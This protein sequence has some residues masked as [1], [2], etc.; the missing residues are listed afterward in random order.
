MQKF[1]VTGMSCAACS[2]RV[3]KAVNAVANVA[4]CNVNLLTGDMTVEGGADTQAIIDAVIKAGYGIEQT[5][6]KKDNRKSETHT[7]RFDKNVLWRLIS[8]VI[9]TVVLMY[10][11]MFHTMWNAPLPN[12][13]S[14]NFLAQALI[15]LILTTAVMVI[16]QRFFI[17]GFKG[18]I[19]RAPNMDTLVALGSAAA[20]VYSLANVFL[21]TTVSGAESKHLLHGLYFESAAMILTLITVGKLLEGYA[22]GKTTNAIKSLLELAPKT[23]TVIKDGKEIV[24]PADDVLKD[25]IFVVLPGESLAVDGLVIEGNS[26]V[27]E[28]SLTGE[29]IPVDKFTGSRVSSGTINKTGKLICRAT[30]VGEDST[31]AQI[32]KMVGDAAATKA[33]IARIADRVSAVFVPIVIVISIVTLTVWLLFGETVGFALS[34]AISVLVISCP[35]ALGLATPVAIMVGSGVGARGGILFKNAAALELCGKCNIAVLDKTGTVTT[36]KPTVADVITVNNTE[37]SRLLQIAYTLESGSAHPLASAVN[38]YA[39]DKN[40]SALNISNFSETAGFGVSGI[41]DEKLCF[42][43]S[44]SAAQEKGIDIQGIVKTTDKFGDEGKTPLLFVEDGVL[45]G[46]IAVADTVKNDARDAIYRFKRLGIRVVMLTGDNQKTADTVANTVGIDEVRA[47]VKPDGKAVVVNELK[48]QGRVIMVGDGINDAPALTS[49]DIGMAVGG[50]MD[51]AV[52]SADVVLM[53]SNLTDAVNAV[54]LSRKTLG[55][56]KQ[57]LFWAFIYN[58][59]GIPLAA[60][61]LIPILGL[62]LN[63]MFAAA[64]MSLSSF[65]V[66]TNALRLNFFKFNRR[67]G[68]KTIMKKT[69]KIEGLMCAHCEAHT[70]TALEEIGGVRV[71]DISHKTGV[72]IVEIDK[73]VTDEILKNTIE[74]EGYNVIAIK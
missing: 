45:I 46:I 31:L 68:E 24:T 27:D 38:E 59:I 28:S 4:V 36:G 41:I 40:I 42:A 25:D 64:A 58:T 57:N 34:R 8:S 1:K 19:N 18:I 71:L 37:K 51:I 32:V 29:S 15:Q 21:M 11:S 20:Y 22:K 35:C 5:A 66:V 13:I 23:V 10:F 26:A 17:K 63:P 2:A 6:S 65:C 62:T 30:A 60:G 7:E 56:I 16:N 48:Q 72:A 73:C 55:N 49:A 43:C 74:S 44:V 50:G 9:L 39:K 33:P 52:E 3:E 12:I 69:I 61:A 14:S 53:N 54:R 67:K 47:D 70:K